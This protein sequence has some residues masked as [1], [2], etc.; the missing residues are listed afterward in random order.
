MNS[1][2][3]KLNWIIV[4]FELVLFNSIE[5]SFHEANVWGCWLHLNQIIF[6]KTREFEAYNLYKKSSDFRTA[7]KMIASLAFVLSNKTKEEFEN[8][9]YYFDNLS[10]R[11][12][13]V[14]YLMDWF[15]GNFIAKKSYF[16]FLG[17][18]W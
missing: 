6:R 8:L 3:L 4:D 13:E 1:S 14:Y 17:I 2:D 15:H 16:F 7:C 5:K 12:L 11:I 9:K 10:K 18:I